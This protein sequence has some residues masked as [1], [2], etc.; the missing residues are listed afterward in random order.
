MCDEPKAS[1]WKVSNQTFLV[2]VQHSVNYIT[3][4]LSRH[5]SQKGRFALYSLYYCGNLSMFCDNIAMSS[6]Y[7]GGQTNKFIVS[8]KVSFAQNPN[9]IMFQDD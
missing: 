3:S 8:K 9:A 6:S 1:C 7:R 5:L 4:S 2:Q